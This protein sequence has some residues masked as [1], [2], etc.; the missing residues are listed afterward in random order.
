MDGPWDGQAGM[1]APGK[2]LFT[3]VSASSRLAQACLLDGLK[4]PR[5][6]EK[7]CKASRGPLSEL[8]SYIHYMLL[9][10]ASDKAR[11]DSRGE[12]TDPYLDGSSYQVT[13]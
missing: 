7:A 5:T 8:A 11:P 1:A 3:M 4:V 2:A 9:A 6:R 13:L 10:K 12:E